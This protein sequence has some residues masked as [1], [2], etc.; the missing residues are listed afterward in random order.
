L[1]RKLDPIV[2]IEVML[3]TRMLEV[4]QS[5][6]GVVVAMV[7]LRTSTLSID[8]RILFQEIL[9]PSLLYPS[10]PILVI[11]SIISACKIDMKL[12]ILLSFSLLLQSVSSNPLEEFPLLPH[13]DPP[14]KEVH[15]SRPSNFYPSGAGSRFRSL[16]RQVDLN[17][18]QARIV[19]TST[20][21][22]IRAAE[23]VSELPNTSDYSG[24][25]SNSQ[26]N[27]ISPDQ[28]DER[29]YDWNNSTFFNPNGQTEATPDGEGWLF[30]P[31]VEGLT[32]NRSLVIRENA[33]QPFYVT[34]GYDPTLIKR[35]VITWPGKVRRTELDAIHR[36][37][38]F[39]ANSFIFSSQPRDSW[40][41][42]NLLGNALRVA[43]NGNHSDIASQVNSEEVIVIGPAWLNN[44]DS[45][46]GASRDNELIF[47]GSQWQSGGR[48]RS[49]RL[50]NNIYSYDVMDF[51]IDM[52]F[53]KNQ[54]PALNQVTIAGHS[55]GGQAVERFALLGHSRPYDDNIRYWVG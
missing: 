10:T 33:I 14:S 55:M 34:S 31:E 40:K 21:D 28:P 23:M 7:T 27:I 35:A 54:F 25:D 43:T 29:Q 9:L 5:Y 22:P 11:L 13:S 3:K 51:F 20:S 16:K 50:E 26:F 32:L 47:H 45:E 17:E 18:L 15:H 6:V 46:A 49:P 19:S 12:V 4:L 24:L 52:L 44:I 30:L 36:I 39:P 42:A 1:E 41:Y 48:A 2:E 8:S 53:D 38:T 37:E